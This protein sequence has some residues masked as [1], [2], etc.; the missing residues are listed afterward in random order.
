MAAAGGFAEAAGGAVGCGE[1]QR[2]TASAKRNRWS[3]WWDGMDVLLWY[4]VGYAGLGVGFVWE[5]D[6]K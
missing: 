2:K 3:R 1:C 6:V 4:D 5:G